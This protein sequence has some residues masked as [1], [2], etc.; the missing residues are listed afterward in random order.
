MQNP[1]I[2]PVAGPRRGAG[3]PVST[4]AAASLARSVDAAGNSVLGI[5]E[6]EVKKT[7][8]RM[9]VQAE[10]DVLRT[11]GQAF[12]EAVR[13][14]AIRKTQNPFYID[15]YNSNRAQL[16]GRQALS[17]LQLEAAKWDERDDPAA[18]QAR[19]NQEVSKIG[20]QFT[21]TTAGADAFGAI[22]RERTSQVTAANLAHNAKRIETEQDN[23]SVSQVAL[24][25]QEVKA[26][27]GGLAQN[28][29][30]IAKRLEALKGQYLEIGNSASEW[31]TIVLEGITS[32]GFSTLDSSVLDLAE[33][34]AAQGTGP[35][36]SLPDVAQQL[37]QS[38]YYIDQA[39]FAEEK[40]AI[41]R[42]RL[43][44]I[45]ENVAITNWINANYSE[46]LLDGSFDREEMIAAAQ[47]EGFTNI[48]A[49]NE[50]FGLVRETNTLFQAAQG[51]GVL[52]QKGERAL[53]LYRRT[54]TEGA[55]PSVVRDIEASLVRG[56]LEL[57]DAEQYLNSAYSTSRRLAD[58]A[59]D[60][61]G[62]SLVF[63]KGVAD[64]A[65]QVRSSV[66]F[67]AKGA[68]SDAVT[69][70]S[71]P[72]VSDS[73]TDKVIARA[74]AAAATV[75]QQG[76]SNPQALAAAQDSIIDDILEKTETADR[77]AAERERVAEVLT[78]MTGS[79][80]T[81]ASTEE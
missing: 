49:I 43:N 40:R 4:N 65:S 66:D 11:G 78:R 29:E 13:S 69:D 21:G 80:T 2:T 16:I 19:W 8:E 28:R 72:Y 27:P 59:E 33:M 48:T 35:L 3:S 76:G 7:A 39:M 24:T 79:S 25:I 74:R 36:N 38:R 67:F 47:A 61:N 14:G 1:Q 45:S 55:T 58:E 23:A 51:Y 68:L 71:I 75:M 20:E 12:G 62:D 10:Q 26:L 18:F 6:R 50:A 56:D 73:E 42:D 60:G 17:T 54:L 15:A 46:A 9:R 52:D 57:N 70:G 31:D 41:E 64:T 53:G 44:K 63:P 77:L 22:A 81:G 37:N 5:L 34:E 32:A 30:E